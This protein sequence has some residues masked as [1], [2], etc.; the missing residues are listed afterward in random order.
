MQTSSD[1]DHRRS[2]WDDSSELKTHGRKN[3]E[4][5]LASREQ[6]LRSES[7]RRGLRV[8]FLSVSSLGFLWQKTPEPQHKKLSVTESCRLPAVEPQQAIW[9]LC[10]F[11]RKRMKKVCKV[12]SIWNPSFDM[13]YVRPQHPFFQPVPLLHWKALYRLPSVQGAQAP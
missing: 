12:L 6:R 13:W 8:S 2:T 10:I 4:P 3:L 1:C 5:R 11:R 7:P 9:N